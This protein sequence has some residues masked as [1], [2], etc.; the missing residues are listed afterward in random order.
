MKRALILPAILLA[1]CCTQPPPSPAPPS[2]PA[3]AVTV[4]GSGVEDIGGQI[5]F[6]LP[7]IE[8]AF[9]GFII[10]TD[11][12][13]EIPVFGVREP[14]SETDLFRLRPDWSRGFIGSVA[15]LVPTDTGTV[16]LQPNVT[17]FADLPADTAQACTPEQPRPSD[18]LS[19]E[20]PLS[21]GTLILNFPS[22]RYTRKLNSAS[23]VPNSPPP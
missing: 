8:R 5:P 12:E 15:V 3:E 21:T 14:G 17:N 10:V 9:P 18:L 11:D 6:I 4:T 7:A 19:C 16:E 22:A 23:Y 1:A 2:E 13:D 20:V